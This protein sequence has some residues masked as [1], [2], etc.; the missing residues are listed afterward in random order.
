MENNLEA[1][2]NKISYEIV[3]NKI[4][5]ASEIN[6]MLGVLATDGAYAWWIYTN[7]KIGSN[8]VK[9]MRI[10]L[11]EDIIKNIFKNI[12]ENLKN[13]NTDY[14]LCKENSENEKDVLE[15][16]EKF[17]LLLSAD[18][19]QLLFFKDVLERILIYA[20]YHAKAMEDLK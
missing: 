20:R 6:K 3:N 14:F 13:E 9:L 1:T 18:L 11:C 2:I 17:F 5:N 4:I 19:H 12:L 15:S 8:T 16:F 10:I 7:V